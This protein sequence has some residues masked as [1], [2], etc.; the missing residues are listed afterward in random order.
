MDPKTFRGQRA[1]RL[2]HI[3]RGEAAYWAFVPHPLPP[4][5]DYRPDVV[6]ALSD[7]DRAVGEL[8][9]L[10]RTLPNP[11]LLVAPLMRQEAVLSSRI[12]GTRSDLEALLAYEA[13][14][15]RQR[16][17]AE[18]ADVR[19]VHNYVVAL[20]YALERIDTLPL[21]LRLLREIH[22]KLMQDVRGEYA[23]PG[24]FRT[25]Q[26]WIGAPNST[27]RTVT[28]VP[29][30]PDELMACLD[31]FEKYLHDED[32]HPP[33]V[34]LACVH[35]QFEAIHPFVDGNG[36]LGRLLIALLL[37]HWNILPIP[38]LY[39]SA[40]FERHR[41]EY[42][43][44]LLAV[45][46]EGAWE[47]WIVFFLR[48]VKEEADR[49]AKRI[50]QLQDI[51]RKWRERVRQ[52]TRST[53]ALRLVDRLFVQP[54]VSISDVQRA[55]DLA[56]FQTAQNVVEKLVQLDILSPQ[57]VRPRLYQADAILEVVRSLETDA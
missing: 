38:L 51:Q 40:F 3:G 42:Y 50:K 36:R 46:M 32:R 2:R 11:S 48:G 21:S 10:G 20:E 22:A 52:E 37:V 15:L 41:T 57:D 12:E 45:S 53:N 13:G 49:T 31:A 54:I 29:P 44:T 27:L 6:R 5:V 23:T 33:L 39:L 24:R 19:E 14:G 25:T 43:E 56:S 4:D 7:A 34:R 47:A 35:Y 28:F 1:G 8:A 17:P 30:P 55:L 16:S 18:L 26:N 9:G